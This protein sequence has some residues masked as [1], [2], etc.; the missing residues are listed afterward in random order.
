MF[1]SQYQIEKSVLFPSNE[2]EHISQ[3]KRD[4]RTYSFYNL[5]LVWRLSNVL[6]D[7]HKG[8]HSGC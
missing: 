8:A 4:Q 2:I 7:F 5:C 6:D 3:L 1:Y